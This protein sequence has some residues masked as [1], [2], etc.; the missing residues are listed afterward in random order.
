MP[1]VVSFSGLVVCVV[2]AGGFVVVTTM[3]G[4]VVVGASMVVTI[5]VVQGSIIIYLAH[6]A[7]LSTGLYILLPLISF[8]FIFRF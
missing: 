1:D 8:F 7:N 4:P 3:A 2:V 6:L 5:S